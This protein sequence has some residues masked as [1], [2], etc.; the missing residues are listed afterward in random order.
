MITEKYMLTL[1][2]TLLKPKK[3]RR[4]SGVCTVNIQQLAGLAVSGGSCISD[5]VASTKSSPIDTHSPSSFCSYKRKLGFY[6]IE[7]TTACRTEALCLYRHSTRG[8]A[9]SLTCR[10]RRAI[11]HFRGGDILPAADSRQ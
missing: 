11:S 9:S 4:L 6:C 3:Y 2:T 1:H 7:S 8:V 10:G 5:F